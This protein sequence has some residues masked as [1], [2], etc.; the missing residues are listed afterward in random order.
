MI[1]KIGRSNRKGKKYKVTVNGK[2]IH[3]GAAGYRIKPGT[4]AGDNYCTRSYYI[5]GSNDKTSANYWSRQAWSCIGT[6]SVS[7]KPFFGK[8]DL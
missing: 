8:I 5:K 6:R 4:A 1:V 3:F 2:T 7:K